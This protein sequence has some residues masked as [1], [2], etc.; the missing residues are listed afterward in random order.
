MP[1][2]VSQIVLAAAILLT[3]GTGVWLL[4]NARAVARLFRRTDIIEPGPALGRQAPPPRGVV[5]A[6][7]AGFAIGCI[8]TITVWS[9]A[10][11]DEAVEV[12]DARAS[13]G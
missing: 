11:T 1:L 10:L 6:M 4:I 13:S 8:G 3:S 2:Y 12:V 5:L 9:W 7:L